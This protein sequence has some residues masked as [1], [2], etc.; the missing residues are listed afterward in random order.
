MTRDPFDKKKKQHPAPASG[1]SQPAG[2]VWGDSADEPKADRAEPESHSYLDN[3]PTADWQPKKRKKDTRERGKARWVSLLP[4]NKK[5]IKNHSCRL[6]VPEFELIRYLLEY[7][8]YQ[9]L[10]GNLV[11]ESQLSQNGLTLYP[12]EQQKRRRVSSRTTH[13]KLK[14]TTCRGISDDTWE[15]LKALEPNYPFW[16]VLNRLIEHGVKQLENGELS[17]NPLASGTRTL[18]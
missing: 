6:H 2:A 9:A 8:L 11:F 12:D 1:W 5:C 4:N 14:A 16:Q 7:S 3:I 13:S 10:D 18:Y 15:Q 17:P